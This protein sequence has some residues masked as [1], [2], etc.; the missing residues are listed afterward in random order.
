MVLNEPMVFTGAGYFLGVH[1]PGKRGLSNFM[2][3]A[4]HAAICQAEGGRMIKL[5]LPQSQVGT[6][7]SYSHV[8]PYRLTKADISA[9]NRTDVLL[10]RLFIEPLLGLGY[11]MKDLNVLNRIE[12]YMKAGDDSRLAFDMDFIGLQNYTREIVTRSW[13]VPFVGAKI[14]KAEKRNVKYTKMGWEVYP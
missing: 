5:L 9:A 13:F 10:N 7:F 12:K 8:E 2:S 6:T 4:H 14:V 1:A 11:P 3:S